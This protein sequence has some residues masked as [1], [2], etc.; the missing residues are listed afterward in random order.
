MSSL[1][2][3][4]AVFKEVLSN[5]TYIGVKD[6]ISNELENTKIKTIRL[7][8]VFA[9]ARKQITN[10]FSPLSLSQRANQIHYLN[11]LLKDGRLI[12]SR[13]R[14]STKNSL[15]RKI[16]KCLARC[17][18]KF[19]K[20]FLPS[21]FSNGMEQAEKKTDQEYQ[22]YTRCLNNLIDLQK[23]DD[24]APEENNIEENQIPHSQSKQ[25]KTTTDSKNQQERDKI[26]QKRLQIFDQKNNDPNENNVFD[27]DKNNHPKENNVFDDDL[28]MQR[29]LTEL[30]FNH[31][32]SSKSEDDE[33]E[34]IESDIESEC[35]EN[36]EKNPFNFI[37]GMSDID[38]D[39]NDARV[40]Q[41]LLPIFEAESKKIQ[42][43]QQRNQAL[44]GF[45]TYFQ[46]LND[47]HHQP[48]AIETF[49]AIIKQ[50]AIWGSSLEPLDES[51]ETLLKTVGCTQ[52]KFN[53]LANKEVLTAILLREDQKLVPLLIEE[54]KPYFTTALSQKGHVTFATQKLGGSTLLKL[55][56]ESNQKVKESVFQTYRGEVKIT[57]S[58]LAS[59]QELEAFLNQYPSCCPNKID[60]TLTS[61]VPLT[62]DLFLCLTRLKDRVAEIQLNG[63]E[64]IN[65]QA[66]TLSQHD[67]YQFI[68]K[69]SLFHFPD[70]K[71]IILSDDPKNDWIADDFSCLLAY[72]P[73]L[74][75][76]L[77][78]YHH[79]PAY[80]EILLPSDLLTLQ[81][82]D[83]RY[84]SFDQTSHLLSHC[85]NIKKINFSGLKITDADLQKFLSKT[86]A[87]HVESLILTD[88]D[89]LTTNV[90]VTLSKLRSL[91][92]LCLP[93]LPKGSLP[94]EQLPNSSNPL[95]IKQ[96]YTT[97][98]ATQGVAAKLYTGPD[99]WSPLFQIP[100][101]RAGV[102]DIFPENQK[103]ISSKNVAYWLHQD[104]YKYLTPQKGIW[105]I[106]ADDNHQLNDGNIVEFIEKFPNVKFLSLYNC[107]NITDKG[108]ALLL[109]ASPQLQYLDL[110]DCKKI[111]DDLLT[112]PSHIP[113]L[114]KLKK[115]SLTGTQISSKNVTIHQKNGLHLFFTDS[116]L[117]LTDE[118]L[119]HD[120]AFKFILENQNLTQIKTINLE[121]CQ[122]LTNKMLGLLLD[123][124][125]NPKWI[126]TEN[127]WVE[128]PHRLNAATI[129]IKNC[130]QI[131]EEAFY[132]CSVKEKEAIDD[133]P[134]DSQAPSKID[135]KLLESLN[136][137][138]MGG[139]QLPIHLKKLYPE[140]IFQ[141]N[142]EPITIEINA[143]EQLQAC[144]AHHELKQKL[145]LNSDEQTALKK[146]GQHYLHNRIVVELFSP[147]EDSY[148]TVLK[149][150]VDF[151]S[152]E[153]F[154]TTLS[155]M[156]QE[157]RNGFQPEVA[158]VKVHRDILLSKSVKFLND[159]RPGNEMHK[160]TEL[161]FINVHATAKVASAIGDLLYGKLSLDKM[162]I[163][164]TA[165]LAEMIGPKNF[166][167]FSGH[168]K[169]L[170][171]RIR[172]KFDLDNA[173]Q[174]LLIAKQLEDHK[175]TT[176]YEATLMQLLQSLDE[177]DDDNFLKISNLAKSFGLKKLE[178]MV[179]AEEMRKN[180][181]LFESI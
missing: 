106:Q 87:Q 107:P 61:T 67:E 80:E 112:T 23:D 85:V 62:Q 2:K 140:V 20:K 161:M 162:D 86:N 125:N 72:C 60:I 8:E 27:D 104:D 116:L 164:T 152:Q 1:E 11:A 63:L 55:C 177:S 15:S 21:C 163:Q 100:L 42:A 166:E 155:F 178:K 70:L 77:Q 138:V 18:P 43:T 168:Y 128:N 119:T 69:L 121:G 30:Y 13:Y 50:M 132:D 159:F 109:A 179:E 136:C 148:D 97:S 105:V 76:L 145:N 124:L 47:F 133:E 154:D 173:D 35:E 101:A 153:F 4:D 12:Y 14:E 83:V 33:N 6:P 10:D 68:Q 90:L 96:L 45:S 54:W 79:Y 135:L 147:H 48:I 58:A 34:S 165:D 52:E 22:H 158:T 26:R 29:V 176:E 113:L 65:F 139:T 93:D 160:G 95:K 89:N 5:Q 129:N 146:S 37:H 66:I 180:Q 92:H 151:L 71:K 122:K 117:T 134:G 38:Q 82:L 78:C 130:S 111:T 143:K 108:I 98:L 137:I 144:I 16:L 57:A 9:L 170:L 88:C 44:K 75:L 156:T 84:F 99:I 120:E 91:S 150:P 175:G 94:I 114:K 149:Y 115:I 127:G 118:D 19:L 41:S 174:L 141:E 102:S 17:T 171:E 46:I 7:A 40:V 123:C 3:L 36:S 81:E 172:S 181:R 56:N 32:P 39:S 51:E 59:L 31:S 73:S 131:T 53:C 25:K 74:E 103:S 142:D 28:E 24:D 157:P 126:Q 49:K 169:A 64:E 167:F 110:T